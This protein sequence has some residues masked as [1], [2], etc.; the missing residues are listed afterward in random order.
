MNINAD[1]RERAL[2]KSAEIDW[3][4]SPSTGVERK[5]LERDGDEVARATSIVR[6]AAGSAFD[7]HSHDMG[8][9]FLV[10]KGTFS[11]EHGDYPAGT[12]VRNPPGTSHSPHSKDGCTIFVKLRQFE[13]G[14]DKQF[15]IDSNEGDWPPRGIPG[16]TG[17]TL[18]KF[19]SEIVRIVRYEPGAKIADDPHPGGE[20]VFVLEGELRDEFGVYPAGT[21]LRQPDGSRHSPYSEIG[22]VLYVK[23]GHLPAIE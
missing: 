15:S 13:D 8:E 7:A 14:D 23:R 4:S 11:D 21:W 2:V 10:L 18:H 3:V 6:Y 20:E 16:L 1:L 22:C 17:L 19:G 5:M 12:Y 9:E